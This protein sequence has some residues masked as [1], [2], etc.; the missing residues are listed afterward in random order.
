DCSTDNSPNIVKSYM[1]QDSRIKCIK[2]ETNK[3]V[4]NARN[5]ALSKAT[6]QFI[7]FLDSDDQWN[8]SKLEKQVNFML[9]NDYVIS[10]TS[11][12]LMDENDKKLNKVIKVPPNVDYRRLLKGNIL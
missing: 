2:T 6:G 4:S 8:S 1:Q 5:L 10:F 3:G 9:E 11:Y 7:A 12:E